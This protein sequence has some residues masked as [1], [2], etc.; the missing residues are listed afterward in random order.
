LSDLAAPGT[1]NAARRAAA[2]AVLDQIRCL[3]AFF[4][5]GPFVPC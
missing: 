4:G 2:Q 5:C 3:Q 1:A